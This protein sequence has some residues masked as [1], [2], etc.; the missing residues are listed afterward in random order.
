MRFIVRLFLFACV[1]LSVCALLARAGRV[2][3]KVLG[4]VAQADRAHLGGA[5]AA[6]GADVYSCDPLE[7]DDGGLM[8][9]QVGSNQIYLAG[10]S[11]AAL[12][13]EAN[14]IRALV[15]RGSMSF[16]LP[17]SGNLTL[18]TPAGVL[19]ADRDQPASGQV[20]LTG[21]REMVISAVHGDLLLDTWGEFRSIPEGR[22]ARIQFGSTLA[23]A[24]SDS[25]GAESPQVRSAYSQHKI[26]FALVTAG[27]VGVPS[28][29]IWRELTES[30]S[31]P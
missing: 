18:E 24:C 27:V 17:A 12:E 22:S 2:H 21:P 6:A 31:K 29:F 8:R 13:A 3:K 10:S 5:A 1:G 26:V 20:V 15:I 25:G 23:V 16:S 9:V 7:T 28:Y 30:E 19:R 4:T 14:E 11:S